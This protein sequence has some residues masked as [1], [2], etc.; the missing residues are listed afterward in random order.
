LLTSDNGGGDDRTC[1]AG[2]GVDLHERRGARG[3][4]RAYDDAAEAA[5]GVLMFGWSTGYIFA[6]ATRMLAAQQA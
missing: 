4:G 2:S 6:V 5:T 1:G 3:G